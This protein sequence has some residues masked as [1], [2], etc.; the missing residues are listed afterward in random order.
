MASRNDPERLE[1][2]A[3]EMLSKLTE[4]EAESPVDKEQT[5]QVEALA[6][7][8]P[9]PT[10]T[11]EVESV[12]EAPAFEEEERGEVSQMQDQLDKAEKAMKG[13][14]ARMTKATQEAADL[15]KLNA[16]LMQ[17]VGELKG[18]LEERQKDNE[19]LAKIRE[20]YPDIAGPLLDE[21]SRTQA[22]VSSTKDALAAEERRRQEAVSAQAQAEHFD[23]IRAVHP[24]VD[25]LI[26]TAD[27]IN[28]LEVQDPRTHEWVERGSSNDVNAILTRFKADMG[29]K[30]PTPQEQALEKARKVAEPKMPKTRK[31]NTGGKKTW[32]VEEI[33][34]MPNRD[35]EKYQGEILKAME[36]GSI[37]R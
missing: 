35:F 13:A 24:D 26:E 29:M 18:Q 31:P 34:R 2:E 1:A 4:T 11:V 14:Q 7:E 27:W 22:E 6:E 8:T 28:W 15:R 32:T 37:R 9:E 10:D 20:E 5:E 17:A 30:P 23:R 19:Q 33:K 25:Q 12:D 3:R 21:L 16:D 36:Q